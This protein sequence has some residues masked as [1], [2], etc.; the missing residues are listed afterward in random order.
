MNVRRLLCRALA[1]LKRHL[2]NCD[3][4]NALVG[5]WGI[6]MRKRMEEPSDHDNGAEPGEANPELGLLRVVAIDTTE[7]S[8]GTATSKMVL[9]IGRF[10]RR[11]CC[12]HGIVQEQSPNGRNSDAY[13]EERRCLQVRVFRCPF[14][15]LGGMQM[16]LSNAIRESET[17][18]GEAFYFGRSDLDNAGLISFKDKWGAARQSTYIL[19]AS[20]G[21]R[22]DGH[23][24]S[25]NGVR[26]QVVFAAPR[27]CLAA[28]GTIVYRG[29]G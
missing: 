2:S 14:H 20:C 18:G 4:C 21:I 1:V 16:L 9:R 19:P 5:C 13:K 23:V 10:L 7:A 11:R 3:R 15:N 17:K 25:S 26:L 29:I 27:P 28:V 12:D 22:A 8:V 6:D 24:A